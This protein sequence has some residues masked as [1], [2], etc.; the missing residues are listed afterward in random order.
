[1][2]HTLYDDT[3]KMIGDLDPE[4]F[5]RICG[6]LPSNRP[7]RVAVAPRHLPKPARLPDLLYEVRS[8]DGIWIVDSKKTGVDLTIALVI[9][10]G[11]CLTN[12]ISSVVSFTP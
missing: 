9:Q 5:L 4:A 6:A 11:S 8:G 7:A 10:L 1:M 2:S 3:L 12:P